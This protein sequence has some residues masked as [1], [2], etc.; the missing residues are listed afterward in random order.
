MHKFIS[1]PFLPKNKVLSAVCGFNVEGINIIS[2]PQIAALPSSVSRHADLGLC[3]IGEGRFVCPPDTYGYYAQRLE[4]IGF[5]VI[6]A[7]SPLGSSYPKDTAYNIVAVGKYAFVNPKTCEKSLMKIL[8]NER[9]LI[10]VKQGYVKCSMC[11]VS[12]NAFITADTAI[13][14]EGAKKG[15]DVLLISNEGVMLPPYKNGFFGGASGKIS[16]NALAVNGNLDKM[17]SGNEIR[18]FLKKYEIKP[19]EINPYAPFDTGSLI[20]LTENANNI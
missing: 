9:E 11:L 17:K 18:N 7:A 13:A 14:A 15:F 12:E 8:E 20:P 1:D 16:H 6:C 2:P 3:P 10:C 5:S 19:V 4:P